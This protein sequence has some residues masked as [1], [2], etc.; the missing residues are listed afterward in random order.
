MAKIFI[1]CGSSGEHSDNATW[2]VVAYKTKVEAAFHASKAQ[3][4]VNK[5]RDEYL[6]QEAKNPLRRKQVDKD[7][8][9]FGW[10][11]KDNPWDPNMRHLPTG[12]DYYVIPSHIFDSIGEFTM[13][14]LS[15]IS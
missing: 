9:I 1:V 6:K 3:V 11:A 10:E 12:V 4:W 15:S 2:S 5:S 14:Q 7:T 13:A 8:A